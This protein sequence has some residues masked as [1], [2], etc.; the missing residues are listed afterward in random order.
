MSRPPVDAARHRREHS[1]CPSHLHSCCVGGGRAGSKERVLS[2]G[3]RSGSMEFLDTPSPPS[4]PS[5]L[6]LGIPPPTE[7]GGGNWCFGPCRR[8]LYAKKCVGVGGGGG[9]RGWGV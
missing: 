5:N 2:W 8:Q 9:R 4:P 7:G 1:H 3:E 6:V